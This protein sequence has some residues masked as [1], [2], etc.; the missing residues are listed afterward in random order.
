[1]RFRDHAA[2]PDAKPYAEPRADTDPHACPHT[3]S[4]AHFL[5]LYG[6]RQLPR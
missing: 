5:L 1:M 6:V 2:V 3:H 4:D